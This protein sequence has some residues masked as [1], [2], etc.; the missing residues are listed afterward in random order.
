MPDAT[1]PNFPG[2]SDDHDLDLGP[3]QPESRNAFEPIGL[4]VLPAALA[5]AVP[6]MVARFGG[7]TGVRL[8]LPCF[9]PT[10]GA[11]RAWNGYAMGEPVIGFVTWRA[12]SEVRRP[13]TCQI[14]SPFALVDGVT[15]LSQFSAANTHEEKQAEKA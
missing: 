2:F 5:R 9:E 6:P 12:V 4:S 10:H 15:K 13:S 7:R 11:R 14:R 1:V 8:E 3:D